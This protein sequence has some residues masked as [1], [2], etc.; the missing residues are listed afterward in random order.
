MWCLV[1]DQEL[2]VDKV[3]GVPVDNLK[4]VAD[5][6][7]N[8]EFGVIFFGLGYNSESWEIPEH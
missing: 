2:D 7:V 5:A 8:C 1:A 4:E 6:M 3:G